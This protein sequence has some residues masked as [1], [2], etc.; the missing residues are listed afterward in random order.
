VADRGI[1]AR[2]D[3]FAFAAAIGGGPGPSTIGTCPA[4][5]ALYAD[6][7]D[8]REAL[9]QAW[10]PRR[11]RDLRLSATD[12]AR[13]RPRRWRTALARIGTARD[14]LTRPLA[15]G[16]TTLGLVGV[17]LTTV[18]GLQLGSSAAATSEA[19]SGAMMARAPDA[20]A[21]SWAAST[22]PVAV[23]PDPG[24]DPVPAGAPPSDRSH[25]SQTSL[26]V[27]LPDRSTATLL[28]SV[29]FLTL[30]VGL[31]GL[32]RSGRREGMR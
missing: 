19:G 28:L 15:I 16:F 10:T 9:R 6:L 21:P 17:L 25:A 14:T 24:L 13:L 27:S 3:R 20:P 5:G 2:H 8:L 30:G 26:R 7:A 4:C 1:H 29:G 32:R 18:P 31:F 22:A 11:V 23:A 12:A